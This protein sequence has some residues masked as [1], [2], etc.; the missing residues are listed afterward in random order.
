MKNEVVGKETVIEFQSGTVA[1]E[2]YFLFKLVV[3][4]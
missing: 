3:P 1:M 2:V 4:L